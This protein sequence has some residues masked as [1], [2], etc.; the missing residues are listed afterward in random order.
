MRKYG[1]TEKGLANHRKQSLKYNKTSNKRIVSNKW[2][3]SNGEKLKA[4][5]LFYYLVWYGYIDKE[6]CQICGKNAH[7]HHPDYTKPY[8][9]NWVCPFHHKSLHLGEIKDLPTKT[10]EINLPGRGGWGHK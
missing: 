4:E 10:Y 9:V 2:K 5:S 6:G 1:R 8:T 7:A 3:K